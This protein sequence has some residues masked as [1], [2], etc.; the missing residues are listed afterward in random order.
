MYIE[1]VV[2]LLILDCDM[3]ICMLFAHF[4]SEI[5]HCNQNSLPISVHVCHNHWYFAFAFT[6]DD[7][8]LVFVSSFA[9]AVNYFRLSFSC[10][11]DM[12]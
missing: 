7:V 11:K 10:A 9:V 2:F 1:L 6:L 3:K 5:N 8:I 12:V 4:C